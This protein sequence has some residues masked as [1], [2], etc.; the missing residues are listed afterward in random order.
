MLDSFSCSTGM[1]ALLYA[2]SRVRTGDQ[3]YLIGVGAARDTGHFYN[4]GHPFARH[5]RQD[6]FFI[7]RVKRRLGDRLTVTD[8]QLQTY[9]ES[10]NA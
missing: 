8:P 1:L 6:Q 10:T 5:V 4:A 3:L 2:A 7:R 9:L